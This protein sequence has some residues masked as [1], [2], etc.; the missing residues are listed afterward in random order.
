MF[1]LYL[2]QILGKKRRSEKPHS[3]MGSPRH[4]RFGKISCSISVIGYHLRTKLSFALQNSGISRQLLCES[5]KGHPLICRASQA[6]VCKLH[7]LNLLFV[8]RCCF[9]FNANISRFLDTAK[10]FANIFFI[11]SC[12]V[13]RSFVLPIPLLHHIFPRLTSRKG[14]GSSH[15]LV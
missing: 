4:R 6:N 3:F 8:N 2:P 14:C 15:L 10:L 7:A 12:S 1:L 13:M 9:F 5:H 11:F